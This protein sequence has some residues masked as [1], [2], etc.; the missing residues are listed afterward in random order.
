MQEF[1][2]KL[3][4]TWV[5]F[6]IESGHREL[7]AAVLDA[8]LSLLHCGFDCSGLSIDIPSSAYAFLANDPAFKQALADSLKLVASG[9][10]TDQDGNDIGEPAI[11]F[12][13]KLLEIEED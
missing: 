8:E 13:I 4:R 10:L 1:E 2:A 11:E 12:R 5:H 6:L 9:H 3:H 7:A